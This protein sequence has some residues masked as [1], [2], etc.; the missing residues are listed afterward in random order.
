VNRRTL[1][2]GAVAAVAV[3]A[4]WFLAFWGPRGRALS[5]AR[6]RREQ[7][8]SRRSQLQTE[9]DRLRA[10]Q[11]DEPAKTA[12][13]EALR[14]AIPDDPNLAQ[15]ILDANDAANRAGIDFISIAPALPTAGSGTPAAAP[16]TTT[17]TA[18]GAAPAAES[19]AAGAPS[20]T[21]GALPADVKLSLQIRGGYFQVLDF[22]NR[23]EDLPRLVVTDGVT[24]TADQS[25]RL[26]VSL[27]ARMFTRSVPAGFSGGPTTT[28]AA[29]A[30]GATPT[31][32]TTPAGRP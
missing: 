6:E 29:G 22:L 26:T 8:E 14:T 18:A 9:I 16:A 27:T 3:V 13:L 28:P 30:G 24:V 31:P 2:F 19:P 4:L 10:A 15:F 5:D 1:I 7:A 11:R 25:A 23:L 32:T 20:P 12:R 17:T 21:A